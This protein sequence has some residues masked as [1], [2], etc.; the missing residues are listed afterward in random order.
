MVVA[1]LVTPF[2]P[3]AIAVV[4]LTGEVGPLLERLSLDAGRRAAW[5][6]G[7]CSLLALGDIDEA[8]VARIDDRRALVMPHGGPRIVERVL[9]HLARRGARIEHAD[10]LHAR[11]LHPEAVDD[12]EAR[13]LATLARAESPLAIDLLLDQPRRWREGP[14]PVDLD[15]SRRLRRLIDAPRVALVG[16]PNV[17]KST[18]TNLLAGRQASIVAD[19]PGTTRDVVAC[20]LELAGLAVVWHDTP[21]VR[22]GAEPLER[23]AIA[24]AQRVVG[25]A[26]CVVAMADALHDW[27]ESDRTPDIRVASR[28]DL[29]RRMDADLSVCA[30][31]GEG[32]NALVAAIRELLV[33]EADLR[34]PGPW[35]FDPGLV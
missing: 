2:A 16:A 31:T 26:D 11:D 13:M 21:G 15:R 32:V 29:G 3:G 10:S 25:H 6:L 34:H 24:L 17:G 23:E 4:A 33:P 35:V 30:A 19:L 18:L 27:P 28:A 7:R 20:R 8:V 9:E 12:V 14:A 5:P 1:S 22:R